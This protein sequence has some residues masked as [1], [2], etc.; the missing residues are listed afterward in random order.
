MAAGDALI[1]AVEG[2]PGGM[3]QTIATNGIEANL[4][5]LA[6]STRWVPL[7]G[8]VASGYSLYDNFSDAVT[9]TKTVKYR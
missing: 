1:D 9:V 2:S 6:R 3:I 4:R 8:S 7:A 5:L